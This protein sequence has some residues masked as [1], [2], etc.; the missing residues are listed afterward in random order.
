M[1]KGISILI[2]TLILL[3]VSFSSFAVE[4]PGYEGGINNEN[5]YKEVI[6]IT[7]EPIELE[8]TLEIKVDDKSK[9]G[10]NSGKSEDNI[11]ERKY[12]YT[13]NLKNLKLGATLKRSIKLTEIYETNGKQTTSQKKL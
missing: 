4:I 13:Y 11:Q 7:G 1:K 9:R 5:N 10:R 6:F 8:G 3:L 2:L 12:T